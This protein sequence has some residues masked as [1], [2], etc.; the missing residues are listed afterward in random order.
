M[1]LSTTTEWLD[2]G[3][4]ECPLFRLPRELRDKIYT[5][6]LTSDQPFWWPVEHCTQH[7]A[8]ALLATSRTIYAETAPL[9]YSAN[10]FMFSHP[11][12]CN[13][14]RFTMDQKHVQATT[15]ICLRIRS[16]DVRLW[17]AYLGSTSPVRSLTHDLPAL[18]VLWIFF[19]SSAWNHA[20]DPIENYK[21]WQFDPR[22]REL[23]LSLEHK[24]KAEAR[25]I[26]CHRV[27]RGHFERVRQG[28]GKELEV[29]GDGDARTP[30]FKIF[31]VNVALEL[32]CPDRAPAQVQA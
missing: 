2:P 24:T 15:N 32:S 30:F 23:C 31:S 10:R 4:A 12:D 3:V 22:L 21:S 18:R 13:M 5:Y 26:C 11:S 20:H 6:A 29:D 27:S 8:P 1:Y 14:F 7:L 16:Q 28:V 25:V 9:L 19:R 17:T